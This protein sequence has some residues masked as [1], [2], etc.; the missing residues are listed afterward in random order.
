MVATPTPPA[1]RHRRESALRIDVERERARLLA[2]EREVLDHYGI[3]ASSEPLA[4]ENPRTTTR[5][6]RVG[7]G[8]PVVLLHGASM[9]ATSWAPLLPRLPA[10]SLYLVD[11]PGCGL[12]DPFD[13]A[14]V[15]YAA[16]Q[17]AFVGSVLD[18][19]ALPA[20][21]LIGASLGGW[22]ALRFAVDHPDRVDALALVSAPALALPGARVP[23][24]MALLGRGPAARLLD[25]LLPAPSARMTR[26]M[27]ASIGGGPPP[28]E[29]PA[30]MYDALGAAMALSRTSSLSA[31]PSMYRGRSPL[32]EVAVTGDELAGCPVPVLFVWGDRDKVQSADAGRHAA[33]ILPDGRLEVVPG[34]HGIWFDEPERCGRLLTDFLATAGRDPAAG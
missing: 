6:L 8:P 12:A 14:G 23:L 34:G 31:A 26:R 24:S 25:R 30:A 19:L 2:A 13:H 20:A 1:S 16:L 10:R 22:F 3:A 7:E 27:L 5:V 15:D 32:P 21:P 29:V 17:S 28:D 11:L 9:T 4:L 18:A 33:E